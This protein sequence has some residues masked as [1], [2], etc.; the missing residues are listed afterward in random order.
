MTARTSYPTDVSDEEWAFVAPFLTL[1]PE[2]AG[3]R[4]Y[5]LREVFNALRW[6]MPA[7]AFASERN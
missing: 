2:D 4:R 7:G 3:Q 1:L 6:I 5:N